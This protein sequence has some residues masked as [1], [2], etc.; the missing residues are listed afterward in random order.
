MNLL[1]LLALFT[2]ATQSA[3]K[4]N[5]PLLSATS[6]FY[7]SC[8]YWNGKNY[9]DPES[10]FAKTPI[11]ASKTGIR[12]YGEVRVEA[13]DGDCNNTTA[14]F[15]ASSKDAE[16]KLVYKKDGGGNGIRLI[17]WSQDGTRLLFEVNEWAYFSDTGFEN[18][19]VVYDAKRVSISEFRDLDKGIQKYFGSDC[20]FE[21]STKRWHSTTQFVVR[22]TKPLPTEDE[23]HS[24]V[25]APILLLY[26]LEKRE[27]SQLPRPASR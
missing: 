13:K 17:G 26:D 9:T 6:P 11:V 14:V 10:R 1:V 2:S 18:V 19:S 15:I 3:D 4:Q 22:V 7:L 23:Q 27:V 21:H 8:M 20:D 5:V 25:D 12:A 24:C 16:F